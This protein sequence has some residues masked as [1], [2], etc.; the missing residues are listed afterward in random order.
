MTR[1]PQVWRRRL[2]T[3]RNA[4]GDFFANVDVLVTP[5]AMRMPATVEEA[6]RDPP[7]SPLIRNTVQ[8]NNYGIPAIS[9]PCG[10]TSTNLPIGLQLTGRMFDETTL[11]AAAH[12]HER[13]TEWWKR[14]PTL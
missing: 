9:V 2:L 8:F 11:L 6:L 3:A 4:V 12:A 5:C 1:R 10:F 13:H 7:G 14:H